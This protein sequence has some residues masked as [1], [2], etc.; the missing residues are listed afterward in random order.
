MSGDFGSDFITL[1]DE[2][3]IEFELEFLNTIEYGNETY[4]AFLPADGDENDPDYG[5]IILKVTHKDGEEILATVD[6]DNELTSIYEHYMNTLLE[7]DDG[8]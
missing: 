8:E 6:D 7:N 3:G 1:E 5:I 4:K 2:A